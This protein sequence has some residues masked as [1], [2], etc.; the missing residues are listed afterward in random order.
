M[1]IWQG[2]DWAW[3]H[4]RIEALLSSRTVYGNRVDVEHLRH[5][6]MTIL[7]NGLA[8]LDLTAEALKRLEVM[9]MAMEIY[10][11]CNL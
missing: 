8:T 3:G 6:A 2:P 1:C 9:I 5:D 4:V 7:D 11:V 10:E